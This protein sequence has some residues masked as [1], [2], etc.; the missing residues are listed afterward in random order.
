MITFQYTARNPKGGSVKG[1]VEAETESSAA[2]LIIAQGLTP[3]DIKIKEEG[4]KL[5]ARFTNRISAKDRIIF[6]RQLA[7]LIN[8]GLP[9][10]Q[11]LRTVSEQAD[12]KALAVIINQVTASVEGG[13]SFADSLA[14]H[15]KLFNDVYVAL[16]AAGES[17]GTLD[18]ALERIANQQEKDADMLSKVRGALVYPIIVIVVIVGVVIFLLTTVVPQIQAIYKDFHKDLPLI[19]AILIAIAKIIINFWWLIL[20][21]LAAAG[22]FLAKWA[23]TKA[24]TSFFDQFKLKMPLFGDMFAKLYM[25]RFCRTGQTLISSGVPM[26]EMLRITSKAVDN[27]HISA[28]ID[29]ASEKVKGGK[30]LSAALKAEEPPFLPLVPQMLRV[31]EQSGSI[32]AMM[33][34]AATYYENELDN[35]IKTISTTIEPVLMVVLAIVV[36]GIV[37]SILLPVY[38]LASSSLSA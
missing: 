35:K 36:G 27:V 29:R 19:T 23:K 17:S 30:A 1:L 26:L 37:L 2:K 20:V 16:V 13:T 31:G 5:F 10:T 22:Y 9:L 24:G 21:V 3:L 12:N 15:P 4:S 18:Q 38:S 8:A 34:K 32:D 14:K 33:D 6:T 11:S 28:S 7:T 25:A